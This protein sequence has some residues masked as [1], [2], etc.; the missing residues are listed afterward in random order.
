MEKPA[1]RAQADPPEYFEEIVMM[2]SGDM[3]DEINKI[4]ISG[5]D[6]SVINGQVGI[7]GRDYK[8]IYNYKTGERVTIFRR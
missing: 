5:L 8:R 3:Q 1:R 6:V 2:S 7:E 4:I